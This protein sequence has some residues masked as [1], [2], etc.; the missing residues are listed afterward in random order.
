[1]KQLARFPISNHIKTWLEGTFNLGEFCSLINFF[2]RC[3]ALWT[4]SKIQYVIMK[5]K[6]SLYIYFCLSFLYQMLHAKKPWDSSHILIFST[7]VRI[8]TNAKPLS[9]LWNREPLN[10]LNV[11]KLVQNNHVSPQTELR[12]IPYHSKP[13]EVQIFQEIIFHQQ[14]AGWPLTQMMFWPDSTKIPEPKTAGLYLKF[15]SILRWHAV[16]AAPQLC[17]QCSTFPCSDLSLLTIGTS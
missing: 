4:Y 6:E 10:V 12:F 16:F 8:L 17:K 3:I 2:W 13:S 7:S 1:M 11:T 9:F 5:S 14:E 15:S